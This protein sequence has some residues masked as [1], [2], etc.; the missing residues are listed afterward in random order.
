M[1]LQPNDK[2]MATMQAVVYIGDRL[3]N[4]RVRRALTQ[5]ELADRAGIGK[6]TVNRIERNEGEP[7]MSTLRKLA[8][9]L[10]V[11]P[12]ELIGE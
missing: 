3:K 7:H 1:Q 12:S 4:L 9:A 2:E 6:N 8:N 11:D 10:D 5:Q